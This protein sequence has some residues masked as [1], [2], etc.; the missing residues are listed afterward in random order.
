MKT[1]ALPIKNTRTFERSC[2]ARA[3]TLHQALGW[4]RAREYLPTQNPCDF[5]FPGR[6]FNLMADANAADFSFPGQSAA[7][8]MLDHKT[9][10]FG[11]SEPCSNYLRAI[12]AARM[13]FLESPWGHLGTILAKNGNR[14]TPHPA[15]TLAGRVCV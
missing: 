2:L 6:D 12:F 14:C 3:L 15:Q 9:L 8:P 10:I 13:V 11:N 4:L 5:T 7:R 1:A